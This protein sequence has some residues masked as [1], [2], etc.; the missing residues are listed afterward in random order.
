MSKINTAVCEYSSEMTRFHKGLRKM[1]YTECHNLT[2]AVHVGHR[3]ARRRVA[4][5]V[6]VSGIRGY[7]A[8][9]LSHIRLTRSF[10]G[11]SLLLCRPSL[12]QFQLSTSMRLLWLRSL[13]IAGSAADSLVY[14]PVVSHCRS[15]TDVVMDVH[16]WSHLSSHDDTSL[17]RNY[18]CNNF[19]IN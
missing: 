13:V 10:T 12:A 7:H 17:R 5:A 3:A 16:T 1:Y 4:L 8:C 18:R 15:P 11:A 9:V 19:S 6:F 2:H 14:S